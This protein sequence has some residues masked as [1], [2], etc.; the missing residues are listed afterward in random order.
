[1]RRHLTTR[2]I[3]LD[4]SEKLEIDASMRLKYWLRKDLKVDQS[5][6]ERMRFQRF[7]AW[8][9]DDLKTRKVE[10]NQGLDLD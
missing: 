5:S 1:M 10:V 7:S 2:S 8:W 4:M 6:A 3:I 9:T